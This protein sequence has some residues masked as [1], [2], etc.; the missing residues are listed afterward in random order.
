MLLSSGDVV[1]AVQQQTLTYK[2]HKNFYLWNGF[3]S[4]SVDQM[5]W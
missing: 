5:R 4:V 2:E 3:G 1:V